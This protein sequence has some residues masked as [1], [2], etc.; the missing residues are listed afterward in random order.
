MTFFPLHF[1]VDCTNANTGLFTGIFVLVVTIISL[2]LFL[3]LIHSPR[4][5]LH[6]AAIAVAS[7][8][9]FSLYTITT[10]AA[11]I[12][13]CQVGNPSVE[14]VTAGEFIQHCEPKANEEIQ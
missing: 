10:V 9:E 5:E 11:L 4:P 14:P 2:V 3:V 13:I 8:T 1:S 6:D 12:G 7:I